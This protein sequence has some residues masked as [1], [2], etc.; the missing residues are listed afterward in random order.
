MIIHQLEHDS[1]NRNHLLLA[2]TGLAIKRLYGSSR[3]G[4]SIRLDGHRS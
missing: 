1:E 4:G 2:F 3:H